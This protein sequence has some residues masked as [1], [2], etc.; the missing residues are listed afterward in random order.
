MATPSTSQ[1]IRFGEYTIDL[2]TGELRRNGDLLKLQ[3]QPAKVLSILVSR[4][5]GRLPPVKHTALGRFK[6]ENAAVRVGP[7]G[8]VVVYMGDDEADQHL[9]K[10]V[11]AERLKGGATRAEQ[12]RLHAARVAGDEPDTVILLEHPPVYTAGKRTASYE[13]PVDGT[14]VIV[15]AVDPDLTATWP[16]AEAMGAR[17]VAASVP[18]IVWAATLP[19]DGPRG[20]FF[21]DGRP[22]PW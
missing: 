2:R 10:F 22:H 16:G 13:R 8:R 6:H 20:G 21:R 12:R 14:P 4:A 5:G 3:P 1:E 9:Y 18:G 15:N 19:D 17:P 7:T 11:S